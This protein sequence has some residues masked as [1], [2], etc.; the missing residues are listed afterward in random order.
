MERSLADKAL[1]KRGV[2]LGSAIGVDKSEQ[3][4]LELMSKGR[5]EQMQQKKF[6]LTR[7]KFEVQMRF[8]SEEMNDI[9]DEMKMLDSDDDECKKT[10]K[11]RWAE[12]RKEK[13]NLYTSWLTVT[14]EEEIRRDDVEI[15]WKNEEEQDTVTELTVSTTIEDNSKLKDPVRSKT[16]TPTKVSVDETNNN[17]TLIVLDDDDN[18]ASTSTSSTVTTKHQQKKQAAEAV[19]DITEMEKNNKVIDNSSSKSDSQ[20]ESEDEDDSDF[21]EDPNMDDPKKF[22]GYDIDHNADKI[23]VNWTKEFDDGSTQLHQFEVRPCKVY[24][25]QIKNKQTK[26]TAHFHTCRSNAELQN[27]RFDFETNNYQI[28]SHKNIV[29]TPANQTKV[30]G[31]TLPIDDNPSN[32][33]DH[34]TGTEQSTNP[35]IIERRGDGSCASTKCNRCSLLPTN[36]YCVREKEGSN[37]FF[38]DDKEKEVCGSATCFQCRSQF[39]DIDGKYAN[40]CLS[41]VNELIIEKNNST[42][43]QSEVNRGTRNNSNTKKKAG[44]TKRKAAQPRKSTRVVSART[45]RNGRRK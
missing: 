20:D 44:A 25:I 17:S 40:I 27:F 39:G 23:K 9:K 22:N 6:V 14:E 12:L 37:V 35:F 7:D 8:K 10:L 31:K 19:V 4:L 32:V 36:H 24:R 42:T 33:E 26:R 5:I 2:P 30:I 11:K 38:S 34:S 28:N 13:K 18:K 21:S 41:C 29:P 3:R 15:S 45:N 16:D 1:D 43:K